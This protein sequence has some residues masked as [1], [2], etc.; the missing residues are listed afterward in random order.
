M[1]NSLIVILLKWISI[2]M[3]S[4]DSESSSKYWLLNNIILLLLIMI[5]IIMIL[6]VIVGCIVHRESIDQVSIRQDHQSI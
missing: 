4:L 1:I 5:M 6:L 2:R 3:E